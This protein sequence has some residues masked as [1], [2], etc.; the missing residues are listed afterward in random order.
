LHEA[1]PNLRLC[2]AHLGGWERW[3]E[4]REELVGLPIYLETSFSLGRCPEELLVEILTGHPAP[5]LLF[6]TDGPWT[7]P[8]QE[9]EKLRALPIPADLKRRMV[10]DNAVEYLDL[11]VGV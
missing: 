4:V 1:V 10:W 6:G 5:Y 8:R 3:Q 9:L 11:P 7:D 2:A